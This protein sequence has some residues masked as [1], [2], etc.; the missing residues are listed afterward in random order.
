M[1]ALKVGV[2]RPNPKLIKPII[3][4]I[5]QK[6]DATKKNIKPIENMIKPTIK[7]FLSPNL[8]SNLPISPP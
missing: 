1:I 8:I 3:G 6:V 4:Y 2:V 5:I 7:S